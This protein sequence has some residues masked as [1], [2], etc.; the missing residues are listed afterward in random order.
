MIP[1]FGRHDS[2]QILRGKP[3]RFGCKVCCLCDCLGYLIQCEPYQGASGT[4]DRELGVGASVLL[5][6]V[7]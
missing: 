2:K 5:D 6:L 1:Y 3:I 4:Y 7:S